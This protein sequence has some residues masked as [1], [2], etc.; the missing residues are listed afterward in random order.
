MW[1]QRA[2]RGYSKTQR[3]TEMKTNPK[4]NIDP[5]IR[6]DLMLL[7]EQSVGYEFRL[8]GTEFVAVCRGVDW[9]FMMVKSD[10]GDFSVDICELTGRQ[11]PIPES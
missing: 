7:F 4:N 10:Y 8:K 5:K 9:K 6:R 1:G 3:A 2:N 11:K